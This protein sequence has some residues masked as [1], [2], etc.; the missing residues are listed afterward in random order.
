MRILLVQAYL[1]RREDFLVYP[2][3]LASIGTVARLKGHEI[4]LFDPNVCAQP[5]RQLRERMLRFSPSVVGISLRNID[6]QLRI[7]PFY[8]YKALQGMLATVN[9]ICYD[10]K[11]VIGGAGF[12]MFPEK[13]M[14]RHPL[15]DY[16]IY[17]EGE[18]SFPE[19]LDNLD[20]PGSVSGIYFRKGNEV[21][22]SGYRPLP[23]FKALP[24]PQRNFSEL[25]PYMN[26]IQS[27][28]VQTKRGC[29]HKCLYCNYPQ[30][31]GDRLRIRDAKSVCDEIEY[32]VREFKVTH[33]MF[34][35][36]IFNEPRKHAESICNEIIK[37]GLKVNWSAYMGIRGAT[38]DFL[39]IAMKAGCRDVAF[40]PDGVSQNA[41]DTLRK[42]LK[43]KDLLDNVYL[44]TSD[45][46]LK[47]LNVIYSVFINPPGETFR[48][49]IKTLA[50]YVKARMSL[51]GRG[52]AFLNW[53]R[54]EPGTAA[55]HHAIEEGV[56]PEDIDLLPEC[57]R[58]LRRTFYSHPRLKHLDL[59]LISV[60]KSLRLL[61]AILRKLKINRL[62]GRLGN[63]T[64]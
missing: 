4:E 22:F 15:I 40:S 8:Y 25:T 60:L 64:C 5:Y 42:G 51:R 39:Q 29:P 2:L 62:I 37:R 14:D 18:E 55:L 45:S 48:G 16:G 13:I 21:V 12:S 1:G 3:G 54:I 27:I 7:A 11:V 53:I 56:V 26:N 41:L 63:S 35:D 58:D 24:F 34:A 47:R 20:N 59:I 57:E 23:D 9:E 19:L 52:T 32:L 6:S 28:G 50:F 30:L 36:A 61:K 38:K 33:F 44:V 46:D 31:N 43:E 49:F 17:L 10:A